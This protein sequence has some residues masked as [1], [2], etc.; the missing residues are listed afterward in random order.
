VVAGQPLLGLWPATLRGQLDAHLASG[1]DRSLRGWAA[2]VGARA[3]ELGS[4]RNINF[5]SDLE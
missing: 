3:V 4:F 5:V 2:L 1:P